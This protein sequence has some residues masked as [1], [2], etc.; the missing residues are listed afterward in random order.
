MRLEAIRA[1]PAFDNDALGKLLIQNYH[2]FNSQEKLETLQALSS[3]PRYGG[4]LTQEIKDKRIPKN[5]VPPNV[6]RQLLRVVGSGFIE[7]WGPIELI[8]NDEAAYEKYQ[9]ILT[10]H[11]LSNGDL[12]IGKVLFQNT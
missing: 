8:P 12:K 11:A 1:I 2:K 6:A 7:A 9:S 3:R 5:E 10:E 4:M